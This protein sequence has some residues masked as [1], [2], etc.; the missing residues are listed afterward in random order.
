MG[1]TPSNAHEVAGGLGGD[2]KPHCRWAGVQH[3]RPGAPVPFPH[4]ALGNAR[5]RPLRS[6]QEEVGGPLAAP[7]P[8]T[9]GWVGAGGQIHAPYGQKGILGERGDGSMPALGTGAC[10]L[11]MAPVAF[12]PRTH[13]LFEFLPHLLLGCSIIQMTVRNPRGNGDMQERNSPAP[14][15]VRSSQPESRRLRGDCR[16][17]P[18]FPVLPG[19]AGGPLTHSLQG[20]VKT[21]LNSVRVR[22]GHPR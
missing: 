12:D 5:P 19:S 14:R 10:E 4:V 22:S 13:L 16:V 17:P 2:R 20:L 7:F 11:L 1:G 6:S 3:P 9:E 21:A 18:V 8:S 15:A